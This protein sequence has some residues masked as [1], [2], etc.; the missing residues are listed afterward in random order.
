MPNEN[1]TDLIT[2]LVCCEKTEQD[3]RERKRNSIN[4]WG[5][6]KANN[7][8]HRIIITI[9]KTFLESKRTEQLNNLCMISGVLLL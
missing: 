8:K 9:K 4:V 6:F 7:G 5:R 2:S 1:N 3:Q